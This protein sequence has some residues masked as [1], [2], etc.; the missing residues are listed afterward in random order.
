LEG[1][2]GEEAIKVRL[3]LEI[4][5]YSIKWGLTEG[6][7]SQDSLEKMIRD[8][9]ISENES[10]SIAFLKGCCFMSY[11]SIHHK[12]WQKYKEYSDWARKMF[13]FV[14]DYSF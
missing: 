13:D 7:I 1:G 11:R 2:R 9:D 14:G 3:K 4:I 6:D 10:K 12:N 5:R 8:I